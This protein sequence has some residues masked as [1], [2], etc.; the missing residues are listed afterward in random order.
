MGRKKNPSASKRK[1]VNKAVSLYKRF[2][3][4]EPEFIDEITMNNPDVG[5]VIGTCDGVLYTTRRGGKKEMY[6]HEF[7]GKSCP[8][9]CSSWDG[10]QI[11]LVDGHYDFTEDGI[12]DKK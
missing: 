5:M 8:L 12:I 2:R 11:F 4:E 1:K 9:L 6:K 10:K 7:N 3:E